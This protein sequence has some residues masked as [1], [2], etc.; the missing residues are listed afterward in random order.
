[1][2]LA[3]AEL[4]RIMRSVSQSDLSSQHWLSVPFTALYYIALQL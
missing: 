3:S 4:E 2:E 1:M